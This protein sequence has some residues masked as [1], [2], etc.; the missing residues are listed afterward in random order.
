MHLAALAVVALTFGAYSPL[1][2]HPPAPGTAS[3]KLV[4]SIEAAPATVEDGPMVEILS[5]PCP[6]EVPPREAAATPIDGSMAD[7]PVRPISPTGEL[8][9]RL[10]AQVSLCDIPEVTAVAARRELE[11]AR[12]AEPT[13]E[14]QVEPSQDRRKKRSA[15]RPEPAERKAE[16]AAALSPASAASQASS[17]A[18]ST[19]AIRTLYSPEPEYPAD[20]LA[21]RIVGRVVL[22]V[23]IDREGHVAQASIHRSSGA[24]SLD[25]AALAAVRRWQFEPVRR[26]GIAVATEV[27]IPVRFRIGSS[28]SGS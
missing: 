17:G 6:V 20:A 19:V 28:A 26:A 12:A 13:R 10:L 1:R 8:P 18:R 27:A 22:K 15:A 21:A 5:E 11:M 14:P 25:A 3:I 16:V 7:A 4:A 9:A 23:T 2:F 24:S